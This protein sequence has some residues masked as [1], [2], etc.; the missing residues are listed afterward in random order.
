VRFFVENPA[1]N[2]PATVDNV[3]KSFFAHVASSTGLA[4]GG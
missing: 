4:A 2:F 3:G 1:E